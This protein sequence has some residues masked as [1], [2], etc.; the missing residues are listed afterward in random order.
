MIVAFSA[1]VMSWAASVVASPS[2]ADSLARSAWTWLPL[3]KNDLAIVPLLAAFVP[4]WLVLILGVVL[5]FGNSRNALLGLAVVA[6][7]RACGSLRWWIAG[8]VVSAVAIA[9]ALDPLVVG[10]G[11]ARLGQWVVAARMWYEAPWLGQGPF[12]FTDFY[13][14][15][16]P[17]SLPFGIVPQVSVVPWAH[18]LYLEVLAERGLV[19]FVVFVSILAWAFRRAGSSTRA[20]LAA[21]SVMGL[22]D[23]TFLKPWVSLAFWSLVGLASMKIATLRSCELGG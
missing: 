16:L 14:R 21:F 9:F 11:T 6:I 3:H 22:F 1:W 2:W 12:T 18:N 5:A 10:R 23:L 20:A 4:L 13:L 17:D 7:V 15:W 19:G 8:A